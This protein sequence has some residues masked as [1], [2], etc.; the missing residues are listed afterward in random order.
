MLWSQNYSPVGDSIGLSALVAAIPVVTA[1]AWLA[2]WHVRAVFWHSVALATLMGVY[3][4]L[5]AYVF[6]WMIVAP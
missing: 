6:K 4:M 2:F 3:V 1:R 5:Q